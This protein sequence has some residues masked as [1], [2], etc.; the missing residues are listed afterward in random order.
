MKL[1]AAAKPLSVQVH[2]TAEFA[3]RGFHELN[4]DFAFADSNEKTELLYA[5]TDFTAFAGW[6]D[7]GQVTAI[8]RSLSKGVGEDFFSGLFW[9]FRTESSGCIFL[10][11]S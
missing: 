2:P 8:F 3:Q 11:G 5:L 10:F 7:F 1:L 9:C 4:E 6:R